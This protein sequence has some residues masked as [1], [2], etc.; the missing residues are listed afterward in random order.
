M[1]RF[2]EED[3]A[4]WLLEEE[5]FDASGIVS[6][7]DCAS[8]H[9]D[10]NSNSEQSGADSDTGE[11]IADFSEHPQATN[12][13][14][15]GVFYKG[16]NGTMWEAHKPKQ[17]R[18][19]AQNI[20]QKLPSIKR[21]YQE[22]SNIVDCWKVFITDNIIDKIIVG[23]NQKLDV[24]RRNYSR[25]EKDCPPTNRDEI[26]AFF[27]LLYLIGMKK[28]NH[29][30]TDELWATDG[31]APDIFACTMSQ[32][33]FHTLVQG[34]RFDDKASRA[35][36][37]ARDN[38]APIREIF[39]EFVRQCQASYNV[40]A[41][42]TIDEMLEPF[43]G[44]CHFR[45]YIANKPAKYGI[46]IYAVTDSKTFYT[47]NMEIY[48]AKQPDGP[49][50]TDNDVSAVVKRVAEPVLNGGRN[51][52]MDNFYTSVPLANDLYHNYRTTVVGTIRKN[53]PDLPPEITNITGRAKCSTIFAFGKDPN[54]CTILSYV[55]NKKSKKNV[56]MLS[57]MHSDDT[58]D[59]ST[60][61]QFKPDIITFYNSTKGGVDVVDRMKGEYSVTRVS[62]RWPFTVFCGLLNVATI[63]SQI[64]FNFNTSKKVARK[65]FIKELAKCLI[66]PHIDQRA[67]IPTL[68]I[69]LRRK[70][71]KITGY[72]N[73]PNLRQDGAKS[74]C[75][76]CPAKKNRYS[77]NRCCD[78]KKLLCK[79][80]VKK[81]T[82]VC[83][84]SED[85]D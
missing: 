42:A 25:G 22:K 31:T 2:Q 24:M 27:G 36:R 7:S 78:C 55:P 16:K 64:M 68:A 65:D 44:R 79:E 62:N 26:L 8:E 60:G 6:D 82:F 75:D 9:S 41:F 66:K 10:H 71:E 38:L 45:Q 72:R 23:T 57:T 59:E 33:R 30:S 85:S 34:I 4:N 21:L 83:N 74:K 49:F 5:N 53:K 19:P 48:P 70:I 77:K 29:L 18:T 28:G 58:I 51:L 1:A 3:I 76:F 56:I 17:T 73:I 11:P 43:R 35:Y 61:E 12:N 15:R 20:V 80:H 32:R 81:T 40:G 14:V 46:K 54:K 84:D 69:P 39:E 13:E 50:K 52:T 63:N 37:K 47:V 67:S